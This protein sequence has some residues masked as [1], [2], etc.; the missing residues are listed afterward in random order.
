MVVQREDLVDGQEGCKDLTKVHRKIAL[1]VAT[2]ELCGEE[3]SEVVDKHE[4]E[5]HVC[6]TLHLPEHG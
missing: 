2:K 1:H 4:E 5:H 3:S 6:E